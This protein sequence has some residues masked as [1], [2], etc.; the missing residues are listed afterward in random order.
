MKLLLNTLLVFRRSQILIQSHRLLKDFHG[1]S[2][3][4][5]YFGVDYCWFPFRTQ[6]VI[7]THL[8][9]VVNKTLLNKPK[10]IW[11]CCVWSTYFW[12]WTYFLKSQWYRTVQKFK[13]WET[14]YTSVNMWAPFLWCIKISKCKHCNL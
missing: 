3:Y 1:S 7:Y 14:I 2:S 6:Y 12:D 4:Q 11:N 10:S 8:T 5:A 9:F 13:P